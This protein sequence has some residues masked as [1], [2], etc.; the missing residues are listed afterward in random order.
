MWPARASTFLVLKSSDRALVAQGIEQ[1]FP[2]PCVAR[3]IR[4]EGTSKFRGFCSRKRLSYSARK[5][6]AV[7]FSAGR[8]S[9]PIH[10]RA[11]RVALHHE[12]KHILSAGH[13]LVRGGALLRDLT[14]VLVLLGG[15]QHLVG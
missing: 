3:S 4:A 9:R 15:E 13:F 14:E 8:S 12:A 11:V 6:L 1:R 7:R 5:V 10:S 2:K